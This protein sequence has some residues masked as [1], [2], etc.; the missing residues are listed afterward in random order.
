MGNQQAHSPWS[1]VGKKWVQFLGLFL[2]C[3]LL[4]V[5]CQSS[6]PQSN[7]PSPSSGTETGRIVLGTTGKVRTLDPADAYE[8]LS[9]NLLYNLGDRLYTN[10]PGTTTLEP[11]LAT[12]LPTVSEAGL[13]YTIPLRQGVKFHDGTAFNA[14]AMAFSLQRFLDNGGQPSFLLTNIVESVKATAENELTITLKSPFSA[15]PSLLAFTGLCAL[16]PTAYGKDPK[17]F[18]PDRFVGTGPYQLTELGADSVRLT[19]FPD[20]WGE[21]PTNEG[22]D[23]QIFSSPA[24][25]FSA[26]ETGTVDVA[27]QR[28]DPDQIRKLQQEAD[29]GKL[30]AIAGSGNGIH[31]LSVN[32][33]SKPLDQVEVRQALAALIDR[34][35]LTER[36][37]QGQTQPLYSLIPPS[38][39]ESIP[40]LEQTY[41]DGNA[42]KALELLKKAGFSAENPLKLD[43][44]YRS[45]LNTNVLAS[46]T[47]K[48]TVDERLQG[49]LSLNLQG[50][51]SAT[52]YENLDKGAYPIFMLDWSPDFLDPDN[53]I[54]PFMACEK[55]SATQGC[56]SGASHAQGSFYYSDR[57][58]Q[59]ITQQR[60]EQDPKAREKIFA[61]LQKI[62]AE[63]V[64]FIPLWS[65]KEFLFAQNTIQGA[66]IEPTQQVA[67][68]RLSQK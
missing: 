59:L 7:A 5:A 62:L 63:D 30:Q 33:L 42:E 53:Y 13:V 11:Q 19:A 39:A 64:P 3:W 29:Q 57:A 68:W 2:S 56:E 28:L 4:V 1:F 21:K 20:Y 43:F 31:Y 8:I 10:Q 23:I 61:D 51:E 45:N 67:F 44:W 14:E 25:L 60:K 48:A 55:G 41:G 34:K 40:V 6:T 35:L 54:E 22:I 17:A 58:N 37:F 27:Y 24:N 18:Q 49:V 36:V 47:I 65:N 66:A 9:G 52:A 46:S 12:A 50:V 26:I 15:F 38:L 16:S 32:V